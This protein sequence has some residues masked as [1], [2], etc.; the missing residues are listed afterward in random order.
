MYTLVVPIQSKL[1]ELLNAPR[2]DTAWVVTVTLLTATV[3]TPI[4]GRLGDMYGKRRVVI[5]LLV[6]LV[7][8]SLIAALS[9][10]IIGVLVGRALQGPAT[11]VIPLGIAILRDVIHPNRL[12]TG[13][14]LIS[15][16]M[17]VGGAL[18]MPISAAIT[19]LTDWHLLFWF[20]GALGLIVCVLVIWIVPAS[21]L[22]APGRFD[23]LGAAG[24][25]TGLVGLLLALT[26]GGEWGW[27][28][29]LTLGV[30]L[31][32]FAV[33][34]LWG[35]YQMRAAEPLLDLRVA[36]RP[37][38]LLTNLASVCFGFSMFASQVV[39]PQQLELP[40]ESGVGFGLS[41]WWASLVIM[42]AGLL[43]VLVSPVAGFLSRRIGPRAMFSLSAL[44]IITAYAFT[45]VFSTEIWHIVLAN[46]LIG[47]GIGLGFAAMPMLIMR[48]VPASETGAANGLNA[49][50]RALGTSCAAAVMGVVLSL[51]TAEID[52]QRMPTPT[53]FTLCFV[54]AAIVAVIGFL[55][56][57]AIPRGR[58]AEEPR[59]SFPE[60]P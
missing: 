3:V 17:G 43:I 30:A 52:G 46:S 7:A 4:A 23:Y 11:G 12:G 16:T 55:I 22:R 40:V 51:M 9:T 26:R 21:V 5:A 32:G 49:L 33:L 38:V 35:W 24:L 19:E 20:S 31:G 37:A 34:G 39:F 48:A 18:G 59:P 54:I 56:T 53:A 27:L 50:F 10:N 28:S 25:A 41:L 57:L 44:A 1:P 29:P 45:L 8:G 36:A 2:E 15:A 14:A 58:P 60:R 47:V 6:L 13:V 42:P